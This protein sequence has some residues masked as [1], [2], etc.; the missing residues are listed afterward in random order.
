MDGDAV[1]S[2]AE[3]GRREALPGPLGRQLILKGIVD[4]ED[5]ENAAKTGADATIVSRFH[6]EWN[7]TIAPRKP[8]T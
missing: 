2:Q 7:D 3:L 8:G 5:A 6:G 1:R 4:P